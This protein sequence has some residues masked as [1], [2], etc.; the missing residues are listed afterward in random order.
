MLSNLY[1]VGMVNNL[2]IMKK[3]DFK[4]GMFVI[5]RN[6]EI[7]LIILNCMH[8]FEGEEIFDDIIQFKDGW[9]KISDYDDNLNLI[10]NRD[11]SIDRLFV[12]NINNICPLQWDFEP[13]R[14]MLY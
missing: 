14:K 13:A 12:T 1:I 8:V 2:N 6:G 7:G 10:T 11:Y 4:T 9:N 5:C 3:S